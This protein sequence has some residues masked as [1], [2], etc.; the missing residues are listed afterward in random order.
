MSKRDETPW[1]NKVMECLMLRL[2]RPQI[3]PLTSIVVSR[4]F[5]TF[6]RG[7]GYSGKAEAV[8]RVR[9]YHTYLMGSSHVESQE[10]A[11]SR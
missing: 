7:A 9:V 2:D 11:V 10:E 1:E 8:C 3:S 6:A 5:T 4:D